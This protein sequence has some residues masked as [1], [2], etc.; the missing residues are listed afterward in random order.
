MVDNEKGGIFE[1]VVDDTTFYRNVDL[2]PTESRGTKHGS[3]STLEGRN[4]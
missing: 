2:F 4:E 1:R 3:F